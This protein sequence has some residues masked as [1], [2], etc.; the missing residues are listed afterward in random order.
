MS[1]CRICNSPDDDPT[2]PIAIIIKATRADKIRAATNFVDKTCR[3]NRNSG[4]ITCTSRSPSLVLKICMQ[5]LFCEI[6]CAA[7]INHFPES[8]MHRG[9]DNFLLPSVLFAA[10][11]MT[12]IGLLIATLHSIPGVDPFS[13][14][15]RHGPLK[16]QT[17][18]SLQM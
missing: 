4:R 9:F 1:V 7:A 16:T 6:G 10:T 8:R 15:V 5:V 17:S 3:S 14:A 2:V 18:I 11:Y 12:G 13:V